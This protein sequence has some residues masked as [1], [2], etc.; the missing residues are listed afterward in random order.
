[1]LKTFHVCRV[2]TSCTQ[3]GVTSMARCSRYSTIPYLLSRSGL[4]CAVV[5]PSKVGGGLTKLCCAV[6]LWSAACGSHQ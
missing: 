3:S 5:S 1:M 2:H 6:L 4:H